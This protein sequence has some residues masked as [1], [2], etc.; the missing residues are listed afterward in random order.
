MQWLMLQQNTPD[1]FV[2]ATGVQHSVRTFINKAAEQLGIRLI[3]RATASMNRRV[4][5]VTG[6]KAPALKVGMLLSKLIHA[7]SAHP[8]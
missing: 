4:A 7:T 3:S 2:I 5:A 8:K 6:D 1:D